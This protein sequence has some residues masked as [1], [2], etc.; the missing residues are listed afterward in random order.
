M[1]KKDK[2]F[3]TTSIVY[4]SALPHIGNVYEMILADAIARFKKMEGYSVFFQTGTDEHGQKIENKALMNKM[5]NQEYVDFISYEIK[6]VYKSV[7]I[8]YDYFIRTTNE[9]HKQYV[10]KFIDQLFQQKDIYLGIYQ[11]WYSISE[12][13]YVSEKDLIDKKLPSGETPIW[14]QEEVYF[15]KLSKYQPLLLQYLKENPDL[16]KPLARRKEILNLLKEPLADLSISRTS[17]KWGI[18]LPFDNDHITYVWFDALSN[19]ITSLLDDPGKDYSKNWYD[20][21]NLVKYWPPDLQIIGKD[22]VRFHLIYY[23]SFL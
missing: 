17:F 7:N 20:H 18:P 9:K 12:E 21:K 19:Y 15:F 6:Q 14:M 4:T 11:G 22:I 23:L 16:I 13:S 3:I 8:E 10:Q 5:S 1:M 2:F